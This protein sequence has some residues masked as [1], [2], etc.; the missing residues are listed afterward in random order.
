[1]R[2]AVV[3]GGMLGLTL[4]LRLS[5]AGDE[6][7]VYEAAPSLGGLASAWQLGGVTWD[8]HYHVTLLSDAA[9]RGLVTELGLGDAFEWTTTKTGFFVD[10]RMHGMSTTL[11]F[12]L[13]PPLGPISKARLAATILRAARPGD[14]RALSTTPVGSW[15]RKWSGRRTFEK[16]WLPLLRA[17][18]GEAH[19]RVAASFIQATVARMYAARR[20]GL[21][22][23]LFGYVRGGYAAVLERFAAV[24]AERGVSLRSGARVRAVEPASGGGWHVRLAAGEDTSAH[25]DRVIVTAAPP[26]AA[27]MLPELPPAERARLE[28]VEYQGIVCASLLL[29]RPLS[30]YY[31][32]NVADPA[33]FTAVI[34]MTALVDPATFGGRHLVYL[35]KYCAPGDPL[36]ALDDE[37]IRARFVTGL[38]AL[39]P[40]LR[41]DEILAFRVSRA[42]YVF[43]LPTLG[44]LDRIP[45][46]RTSAPGLYV[47]NGSQ[48]ADGTL[49]VDETV[50]LAERAARDILADAPPAGAAETLVSA[51]AVPAS[52][53]SAASATARSA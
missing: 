20:S 6:V 28:A 5:Q 40:D 15:L 23:E 39:H 53:V 16:I 19:E 11:E 25:F 13:F 35:P 7:T 8:R 45:P 4:A 22:R 48:I 43:A 2:S 18:L 46:L 52:A 51:A 10:G 17:K 38:R 27:R 49:N 12:A 14:L 32:T 3:G 26:L 44:Y 36:L 41:D 30:P 24:L 9:T 21:K 33:P 37:T 34:E 50:R 47:V 29:T 42:P 1:M 31:V